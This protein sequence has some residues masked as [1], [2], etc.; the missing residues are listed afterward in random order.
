ME[1]EKIKDQPAVTSK[2]IIVDPFLRRILLITLVL[3]IGQQ[4]S[5][6]DAVNNSSLS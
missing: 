1:Y 2:D 6:I 3:M 5:G 4:L